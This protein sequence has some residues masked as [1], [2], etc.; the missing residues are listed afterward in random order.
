MTA[1]EKEGTTQKEKWK[2]NMASEC[3]DFRRKCKNEF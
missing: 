1:R 2:I 3:K